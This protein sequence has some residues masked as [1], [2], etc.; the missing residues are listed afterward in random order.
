[1]LAV[2][3]YAESIGSKDCPPPPE[4]LALAFEAQRWGRLPNAG[5]LRDQP[6]GL[7]NRMGVALNVYQAYTLKRG[8]DLDQFASNHPGLYRLW[9]SVEDMRG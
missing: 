8:L 5:G 7:L 6:A 9:R 1:M 2:A 3:D 4:P